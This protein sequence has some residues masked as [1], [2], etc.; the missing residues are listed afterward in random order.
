MWESHEQMALCGTCPVSGSLCPA[1]LP[2]TEDRCRCRAVSQPDNPP[3]LDTLQKPKY[4]EIVNLR[5][6]DG[7]V[8]RGQVL[9]VDGDRAVVQVFEGTSGIDNQSTTLEF[10][11]EVGAG[12]WQGARPGTHRLPQFGAR[13]VRL[14]ILLLP[15]CQRPLPEACTAASCC[16]AA[17][18]L[19]I[20]PCHQPTLRQES[21]Q[22]WLLGNAFCSGSP[23][24][25]HV[26]RRHALPSVCRCCAPP[27]PAT[28]LA[29]CST[30][31]GVPSMA[32]P[33]CWPSSSWTS[34]APPS[35]Q[36]SARTLRR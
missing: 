10:T 13:C 28:C 20:L 26:C 19:G 31:R 18:S 33:R 11:G 27:C 7:S 30:A 35:T 1:L 2:S 34:T 24:C 14:P 15:S 6:G 22:S 17:P 12:G 29:A 16:A 4:A 21:H 36:Q 5:L 8:R 32:A 23:T 25:R 9:E 3:L